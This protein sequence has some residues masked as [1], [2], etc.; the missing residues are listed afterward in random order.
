MESL[1]LRA[2]AEPHRRTILQLVIDREL[3]A[4]EIAVR[5]EVTRPA[6]SQHL[7][8]LEAAGLVAVR[9][10]GTRRYYTA[11]SEGLQELREALE[12]FWEG[13][14]RLLQH[15]AEAEEATTE[16]GGSNRIEGA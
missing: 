10:Q 2:I 5:F 14:L 15:A 6:I 3:T 8:V 11:R 9:R 13:R 7:R 4:G 1:A 16:K 12:G